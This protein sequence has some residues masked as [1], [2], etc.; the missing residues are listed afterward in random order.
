MNLQKHWLT[1]AVKMDKMRKDLELKV[2]YRVFYARASGATWQEIGDAFGISKQAANKKWSRA[3]K[4]MQM[5]AA[6]AHMI[7]LAKK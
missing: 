4:T 5:E 6:K 2:T 1:E 3:V 7:D